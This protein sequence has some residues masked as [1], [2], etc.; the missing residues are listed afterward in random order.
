MSGTGRLRE[1]AR[2]RKPS[3]AGGSIPWGAPSTL[4]LQSVADGQ[5][6]THFFPPNAREP[7]LHLVRQT[8][9]AVV[10]IKFRESGSGHVVAPS[11][12]IVKGAVAVPAPALL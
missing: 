3:G 6:S 10:V 8:R 9:R 11:L 1:V 2:A 5:H 7:G 4:A 12:P